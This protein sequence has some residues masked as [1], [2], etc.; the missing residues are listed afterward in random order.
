MKKAEVLVL[1]AGI[2]GVSTALELQKRG[3]ILRD[4]QETFADTLAWMVRAGHLDAAQVGRAE[5]LWRWLLGRV[6]PSKL[7][8]NRRTHR[9]F[10]IRC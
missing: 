7:M 5:Q 1:G 4:I 10:V 3:I 2:V 9:G 6:H 8:N